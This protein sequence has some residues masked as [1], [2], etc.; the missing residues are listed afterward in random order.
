M[1]DK[2]SIVVP[3]YNEEGNVRPLYDRLKAALASISP[4][5]KSAEIIFVDDG[6]TD[7]TVL[8]LMEIQDKDPDVK[9]VR[10]IRNQG[11]EVAMVAGM[12]YA[13]GDAVVFMDADLQHPPELVPEM[14]RL[15]RGGKDIVLT[16][17]TDNAGAGVI[18]K[19]CAGIFY[20]VL[21]FLSDV[22]LP[23]NMPDFRLIDAR[24][25][26]YLKAFDER[27]FMFRGV[28][29]MITPLDMENAA[30]IDF[31]AP[32]R[33]SGKSQYNFFKSLKL[34][35]N[36]IMQF[37]TRPLYLSLWLAIVSGFL[38]FGLGV[39]VI[40]EKYILDNPTPGY[41]TIV[42]A[43]VMMGSLNLFILAI[44][45]AYIGKIHIETKKRPL[46]MAELVEPRTRDRKDDGKNNKRG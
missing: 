24:Y 8:R 27:D 1:K 26:G 46:Y 12:N 45:G 30:V 19:V 34:A 3:A 22:K 5:L 31:A 37:S 11:H 41:A 33:L 4:K 14:V 36:G 43:V 17:R 2:L 23:R 18:Y 39:H 15:W 7:G 40:I 38:A 42:T 6:S 10:L 20:R 44:I 25:I 35:I 13:Q 29:G 9:I 32:A 21:N 28:L 16:R